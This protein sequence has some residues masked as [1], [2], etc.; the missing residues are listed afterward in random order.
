MTSDSL[1][2]PP[3]SA[4]S[5][6]QEAFGPDLPLLSYRDIDE[7]VRRTSDSEYGLAA[8]VWS[9]DLEAAR[10]VAEAVQPAAAFSWTPAAPCPCSL[11]STCLRILPAA[12][13]GRLSRTSTVLG[14]L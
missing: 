2:N 8:S 10:A 13:M 9:A 11:R 3:D 12:D 7:V 14:H 5:V 4:R 1:D 6:M